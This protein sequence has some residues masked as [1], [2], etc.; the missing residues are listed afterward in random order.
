MSFLTNHRYWE[1]PQIFEINKL[2]AH[3][4]WQRSTETSLNGTWK[5]QLF[6]R[7]EDIPDSLLFSTTSNPNAADI[8]VPGNWTMQ[9]YDK[10][11]Y[12][13]VQM[14]FES[15]PP[16][17]PAENPTGVYQRV[18][19]YAATAEQS[20]AVLRFGGVESAFYL[21]VNGTYVGYSQGSRLPAEFEV[22]AHLV[23]GENLITA[24]VI[25]WSD[26]SYI[27]D[28]DHWWH[29]GIYRDV[30]LY[31]TRAVWLEDYFSRTLLDATYTD[32]TLEVDIW[33]Q[34]SH[35]Q[36]LLNGYR[37]SVMLTDPEW[38]ATVFMQTKP[39]PDFDLEQ[40]TCVKFSTTLEAPRLWSS[41]APNLYQLSIHVIDPTGTVI[42]QA[43]QMI[44]VRQVEIKGKEILINGQPVMF[45]GVNRHE[46][47]EHHGKVISR[48]S[49]LADIN[50]LKAFNF[51][52][53]RNSHYPCTEDW[54]ALCD[55]HGL[56]VIDEANIEC[57][58]NYNQLAHL[59]DW[60]NA[61]VARGNRMVARTKNHPSVIMWSLGNEAGYGP[62]QDAMAGWIRR[63]DP[64]RPLH[65]EGAISRWKGEDWHKGHNV[66]DVVCP[67]YPTLEELR[68]YAQDP[69]ADRPLFMCEYAHSMGNS[70]GN[71]KEYWALMES[72]PGLQGG[73]IWDW[74]DQGLVKIADNGK[75][76][77]AYGGDYGH[78]IN[79][80]NFCINGLIW[81][82]RTPH[83]AMWE[84]HKLA[85]PFEIEAV[86]LA[87]R[88][89]KL[90]NR[91][92]FTTLDALSFSYTVSNTARTS[93]A[94]Q[95]TLPAVAPRESVV[96]QLP[97]KFAADA[98]LL[99]FTA[100]TDT[101]HVVGW[102]QCTLAPLTNRMSNQQRNDKVT[103]AKFTES[104]LHIGDL[105]RAGTLQ[106]WRAP[107]DNDGFQFEAERDDKDL[108][109]WQKAGLDQ[110]RITGQTQS[111]AD[112]TQQIHLETT[113]GTPAFENAFTVVHNL[114]QA[115]QQLHLQT[116]ITCNPALPTLPRLGL[117][118]TF[119]KTLDT[120]QWFG[121]G[122]HENYQ[123]RNAGA[124]LG[125][126]QSTVEDAYVPYIL[127]QN[128][129]NRTDTHWIA[130]TNN[131]QHGILLKME[132]PL[133]F[134]V[135]PYTEDQLTAATH[136]A[137]LPEN[138][139]YYLSLDWR[140]AGLGGASCGPGTLPQYK[141]SPSTVSF[142]IQIQLLTSQAELATALA[143]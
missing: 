63:V 57:H 27:E 135:S 143:I 35:N 99:T 9:G 127:P 34:H 97:A 80:K 105:L 25:R 70:T 46:H 65:Y 38:D 3:A 124:A 54:Y 122:P 88:T 137:N 23:E 109:H 138:E 95:L 83:P 106:V 49:M 18:F 4:H 101:G 102:S 67:M 82:D 37:V 2:A 125:H 91:R 32:A 140:Q 87:Q 8:R 76:Y 40:V 30:T 136:T 31:T 108:Y 11:I 94:Q 13:N 56:Y 79:D 21:F 45:Y 39:V 33:P 121:R 132:T 28:Q 51:N 100:Q 48:E 130:L 41:E 1:T 61:F 112:Q 10:P 15:N 19:E 98:N 139:A 129:G 24:V 50:L 114:S 142:G 120:V 90:T 104:G 36:R 131:K 141:V 119:P 55:Q 22:T 110:L 72:L 103:L 78:P 52:A 133:E 7:P 111:Q 86:D 69:A 96:F 81:P 60:T 74:V 93:P 6:E 126:W 43:T 85:Q 66:T 75:S 62:N 59:P 128:N 20:R 134:T 73:F 44:G 115:G 116:T 29:A 14:P 123:D 89:F 47:D 42:D 118:F 71:L 17:V 107:T 5:F 26:A 77:W 53:V 16:F 58:A 68:A 117:R 12:T 64:T 84:C 113:Y 92:F